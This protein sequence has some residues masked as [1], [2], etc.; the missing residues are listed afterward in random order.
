M[1]I[2]RRVRGRGTW[3]G[4]PVRRTVVDRS[5]VAS[6]FGLLFLCFWI[7]VGGSR[8]SEAAR[9]RGRKEPGR[10]HRARVESHG[11]SRCPPRQAQPGRGVYCVCV[12][13]CVCVIV[14]LLLWFMCI[15]PVGCVVFLLWRVFACDHFDGQSALSHGAFLSGRPGILRS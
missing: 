11:S 14:S 4:V 15:F 12:C 3:G 2:V 8:C 13:V 5:L 9:Y 6:M 10:H 7:G 1:L